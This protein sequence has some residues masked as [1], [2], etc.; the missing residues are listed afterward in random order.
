[1]GNAIETI[2]LT[3]MFGH[4][5]AADSISINVK[6]GEMYG[7]LGLNGAGKTTTIRMLLGM[8]RPTSAWIF[9]CDSF[10]R[11]I[12]YRNEFRRHRDPKHDALFP[13]GYSG[14]LQR[15]CGPGGASPCGNNKLYHTG[16]YEHRRLCR[17]GGM[18]AICGSDI[19]TNQR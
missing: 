14:A 15:D 1:M 16:I 5:T 7:F 4:C 19:S 13:L 12:P 18:V 6:Q 3:K 10:Y 17:Y 9:T 8:V 2:A 11:S